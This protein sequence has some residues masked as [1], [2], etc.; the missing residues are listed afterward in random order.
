MANEAHVT[1]RSAADLARHLF[2]LLNRR[3]LDAAI[4]LQH[5]DVYEDFLVLRPLSG[6]D[7]VRRFFDGLFRAFPDFELQIERITSEGETA[8]V[9]WTAT[10]TFSGGPFEGIDPNGKRVTVRGIDV[11]QFERG[12]LRRNTIYYDGMSFARQVGLLPDQGSAGEKAMTAAFNVA[13]RAR[14]LLGV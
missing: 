5:A 3:D 7:E 2:E 1:G 8:A 10:G 9:Q 6:R 11:M 12:L 13:T 14:K 4:A